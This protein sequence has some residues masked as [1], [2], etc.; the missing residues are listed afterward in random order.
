MARVKEGLT[1]AL[2][3][4]SKPWR[5]AGACVSGAWVPDGARNTLAQTTPRPVI[6]QSGTRAKPSMIRIP[7][8]AASGLARRPGNPSERRA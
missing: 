8:M 2:R 1:I 4:V 7:A 5:V 6:N 3:V